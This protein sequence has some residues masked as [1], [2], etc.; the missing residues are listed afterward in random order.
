MINRG[1]FSTVLSLQWLGTFSLFSQVL[2]T[3]DYEKGREMATFFEKGLVLIVSDQL[4]QWDRFL[5][6]PDIENT[7]RKNFLFVLSPFDAEEDAQLVHQE[8][9]LIA[10]D[11]DKGELFHFDI[12][13]SNPKRAISELSDRYFSEELLGKIEKELTLQGG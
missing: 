8:D 1:I 13:R 9:Q 7:I 6:A 5:Q 12:D 10:F 3:T 11:P 2:T 4:D